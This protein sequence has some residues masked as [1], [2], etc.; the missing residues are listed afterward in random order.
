MVR[1]AAARSEVGHSHGTTSSLF[2]S[3]S[4]TSYLLQSISHPKQR[5][6]GITENLK[7]RLSEHNAGASPHTSKWRPWRLVVAICFA[8]KDKAA[9]FETYLK[10]G[11]GHAFARR[12]FW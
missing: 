6:V 4:C 8:D 11:S 1:N 2:L 3:R 9:A 5:Y 7:N 10:K 12:H